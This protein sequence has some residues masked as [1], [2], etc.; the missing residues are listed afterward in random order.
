[1]VEF[2]DYVL[3]STKNS[4]LPSYQRKKEKKKKTRNNDNKLEDCISHLG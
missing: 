2:F 3:T 1:M 4:P